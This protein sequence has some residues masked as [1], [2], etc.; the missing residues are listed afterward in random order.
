MDYQKV[1]EEI[2]HEV[3]D[4]Q[5][6]G[7]VA[8]YIPQ[9][10]EVSIEKYGI[11]IISNQGEVFTIGDAQEKFSIQSISKVFTLAFAYS[12]FKESLWKSVGV[13]P[14]GNPFNSLLRLESEGG[15]PRNPLINSGAL[16]VTDL[17]ISESQLA[18]SD[19]TNFINQ[20]AGKT[21][22]RFNSK[23]AHSEMAHSSRNKA[24]AHFMKSYGNINS[25]VSEL[26]S[27]YCYQCSIE[28]SCEELAQAFQVFAQNGWNPNASQQV[29]SKSETKRI[30]AIMQMCGFYDE[31][32]EFAFKVG[33]PGKSGVGGGMA[34]VLPGEFSVVVWSPAL[35]EKGNSVKG[36]KTLE[37]LT[38]KLGYSVF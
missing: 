19:I 12:K 7:Q 4:L 5:L 36:L 6:Q 15:I 8:N 20:L 11:C 26:V 32:G 27:T 21:D 28:M 13:E 24:L 16:V 29:L 14:S 3:N 1:I 38:T 34:A 10:A 23:T 30:N 2:Y 9:L 35:N 17:I 18:F 22:I 31:A 33:L 25:S 37:L